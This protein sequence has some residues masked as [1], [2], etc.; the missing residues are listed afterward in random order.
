[1]QK[2]KAGEKSDIVKLPVSLGWSREE[3]RELKP[4]LSDSQIDAILSA[5][6]ELQVSFDLAAGKFVSVETVTHYKTPAGAF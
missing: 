1:V 6:Y 3:I 4:G 2:M 5:A